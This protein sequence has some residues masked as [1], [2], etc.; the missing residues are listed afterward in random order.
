MNS[1]KSDYDKENY[2]HW[3]TA[4]SKV[5]FAMELLDVLKKQGHKVLF[6]SKTKILL[7]LVEALLNEKEDYKFLRLDG[8]VKIQHRDAI[9]NQFNSDP[10]INCFLLTS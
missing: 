9:C 8:D 5:E 3:A 7:N 6:F 4:S 2:K 1:I 10:E